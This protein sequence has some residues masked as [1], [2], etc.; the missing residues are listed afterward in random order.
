MY[1][2]PLRGSSN[3]GDVDRRS[4]VLGQA[5][6]GVGHKVVTAPGVGGADHWKPRRQHV[7]PHQVECV[8][9]AL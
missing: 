2:W 1:F 9:H 5:R 4:L 7:G 8:V 6:L 3:D